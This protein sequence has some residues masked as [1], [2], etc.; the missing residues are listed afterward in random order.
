MCLRMHTYKSQGIIHANR[1]NIHL[2]HIKREF[3]KGATSN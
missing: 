1:H 3:K 2:A